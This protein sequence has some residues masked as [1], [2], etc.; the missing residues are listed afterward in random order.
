MFYQKITDIYAQCSID[1][2]LNSPT[3]KQ[4]F[5]TV[6]NKLEFAITHHTAAEIIKLRVGSGKP[7]MGL[8]SWKNEKK[9]GKIQKSDVVVAKNYLQEVEIKELN[10]I[11]NMYLDYVENM[12]ER[13]KTMRM[14]DWVA[15]LENFLKFNE[16]DILKDAGKVN[17]SVADAFAE[18]E[19]AKFRVI[20]DKEYE[21]DF[22]RI[23]KI[24]KN[25]WRIQSNVETLVKDPLSSFNKSLKTAL[26]FNPKEDEQQTL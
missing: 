17:K 19:Y 9:G 6:Q 16:Y 8:T 5:E 15:K 2:A 23:S 11:V 4:F 1:Y 3:T 7:N 10:R 13:N 25:T 22:D 14:I 24:I 18:K 20:Q 12:A 26:N 21:S